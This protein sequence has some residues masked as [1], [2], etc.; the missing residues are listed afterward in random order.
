[1]HTPASGHEHVLRESCTAKFAH[2]ARLYALEEEKSLKIACNLK[3]VSLN[4]SSIAR[5]SPQHALGKYACIKMTNYITALAITGTPW[6]VNSATT[7]HII[8]TVLDIINF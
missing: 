4:P 3:K 7:E 2:I 6:L 5:T 1:M 8:Y